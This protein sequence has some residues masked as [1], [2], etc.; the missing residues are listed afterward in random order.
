MLLQRL[1]D[2][3]FTLQPSD[4]DKAFELLREHGNHVGKAVNRMKL[5][6]QLE[7]WS[8]AIN[9]ATSNAEAAT[10]RQLRGMGFPPD[11]VLEALA[12]SEGDL[13]RAVAYL[14]GTSE[15]VGGTSHL[16]GEKQRYIQ[17]M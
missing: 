2:H 3:G 5:S 12:F 1:L 13:Y 10:L 4:Q 8:T 14:M 6:G 15:Q 7:L 16:E 17:T 9:N 11:K